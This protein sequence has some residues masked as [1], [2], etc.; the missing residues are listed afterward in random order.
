MAESLI[1]HVE[2][3]TTNLEKSKEFYNKV[4]GWDFKPFGHGYLLF[5]NHKGTMV[6]LRQVDEVAKG[7]ATVFHVKIPDI[8]S[9]LKKVKENGGAIKRTKTVIPAM[10]W[11]ALFTDP[12]G[13]TIG[14]Y[15]KS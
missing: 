14:L 3:P 7:E 1:A 4:L 11:Y 9:I 15:Q 2:I 6:G 5:N 10:G 8:D 13:N 12:D